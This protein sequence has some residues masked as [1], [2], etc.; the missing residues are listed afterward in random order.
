L[1]IVRFCTALLSITVATTV[2]L[3]AQVDGEHY[4]M[5]DQHGVKAIQDTETTAQRDARME[6]WRAARFGM[7]IHGDFTRFPPAR[8]MANRFRGSANGS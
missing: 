4:N 5:A 6:W 1:K 8:G 7:F 2:T 3:L